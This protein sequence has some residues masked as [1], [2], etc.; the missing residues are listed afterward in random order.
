MAL[1][2]E[3]VF[4]TE[5]EFRAELIEKARERR[6]YEIQ[7]GIRETDEQKK[8]RRALQSKTSVE[9]CSNC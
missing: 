8:A 9:R 4:K 6:E 7:N 5:Q 1:T 2:I 3:H